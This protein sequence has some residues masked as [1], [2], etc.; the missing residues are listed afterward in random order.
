MKTVFGFLSLNTK[1]G[2]IKRVRCTFNEWESHR[3]KASQE[4]NEFRS[5]FVL[6]ASF[7]SDRRKGVDSSVDEQGVDAVS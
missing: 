6:F 7:F 2:T 3:K 1:S 5:V 4:I